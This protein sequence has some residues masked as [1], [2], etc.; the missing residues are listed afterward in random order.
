[1]YNKFFCGIDVS[2]KKLDVVLLVE[3]NHFYK[4]F[5]NSIEGIEILEK[6][7]SSKVEPNSLIH[8]CIEATN[9][10]HELAAFSLSEKEQFKVSVVNPR[11][12]KHFANVLVKTKTDK[13]DAKLLALY[14]K[15]FEP[16]KFIPPSKERIELRELSRLMDNLIEL[17]AI[18]K[19]RLQTFNTEIAAHGVLSTIKSIDKTIAETQKQINSCYDKSIELKNYSKLLKSIPAFGERVS[20]L[21]LSEIKKDDKGNFH[22][23]KMTKYFGLN[24]KNFD[25]GDSVHKKPR[26]VK[27][28]S[29]RVRNIL[30]MSALESIVHK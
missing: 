1:M 28:G 12:V 10:Y 25:S 29:P 24:V 19:V 6:W 3:D 21:L 2:K 4:V 27:Y 13:A 17:R 30:Y 8:I 16:E 15:H 20:S 26:I 7:L 9:I 22:P 14:C 11:K 18:Q 23:K 5:P